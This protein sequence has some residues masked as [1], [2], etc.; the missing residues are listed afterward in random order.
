MGELRNALALLAGSLNA[1]QEHM[2]YG[3]LKDHD[4]Q[5]ID[6]RNKSFSMFVDNFVDESGKKVVQQRV[7]RGVFFYVVL[8]VFF[9]L[10]VVSICVIVIISVKELPIESS[11][12]PVAAAFGTL[13]SSLIMLPKIIAKH[14]F[15][16]KDQDK[17]IELFSKVLEEDRKMRELYSAD[18]NKNFNDNISNNIS[19]NDK[20]ADE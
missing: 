3:L 10:N 14:L 2:V 20:P 16:S 19:N 8:F 15:P 17:S 7:F 12:A 18:A 5:E 11:I 1:T 4:S 13:L 6:K 9:I